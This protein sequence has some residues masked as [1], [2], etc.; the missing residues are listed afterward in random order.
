M[1]S[2]RSVGNGTG[3]E[4]GR[5]LVEG[6]HQRRVAAVGAD[7]VGVP[8]GGL[9]HCYTVTDATCDR[10]NRTF[11]LYAYDGELRPKGQ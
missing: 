7:H 9:L 6:E 3:G 1:R 10:G 2:R 8:D 4:G 5:Q 11:T